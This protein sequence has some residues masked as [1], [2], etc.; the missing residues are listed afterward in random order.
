MNF[1]NP[2]LKMLLPPGMDLNEITANLKSAVVAFN[3]MQKTLVLIEQRLDRIE[4]K[5]GGTSSNGVQANVNS[6]DSGNGADIFRGAGGPSP[7]ELY[8]RDNPA[9][10]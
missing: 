9:N 8:F 5:M 10:L 3:D 2:I 6:G 1:D 7:A 4:A